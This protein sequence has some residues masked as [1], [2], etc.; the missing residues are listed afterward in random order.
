MSDRTFWKY[1]SNFWDSFKDKGLFNVVWDAYYDIANDLRRYLFQTNLNKGLGYAQASVNFDWVTVILSEGNLK[2]GTTDTYQ[3]LS[4]GTAEILTL[5]DKV[6]N[7]TNMYLNGTHFTID[8]TY[9]TWID[10]DPAPEGVILWCETIKMY[11]SH[12][13]STFGNYVGED[14]VDSNEYLNLI[15]GLMNS[16]W[17]GP[18]IRHIRNGL[19]II[20]GGEYITSEGMVISQDDTVMELNTSDGVVVY[21]KEATQKWAWNVG[22]SLGKYDL[23]INTV[24]VLDYIK[25]P[26]WWDIYGMN[27]FEMGGSG[28]VLPGDEFELNHIAKRFIWGIQIDGGLMSGLPAGTEAAISR[29]MTNINPAYTSHHTI[30]YN[31]FWGSNGDE[32]PIT[33]DWDE[34]ASTGG[35]QID[36][37]FEATQSVTFNEVSN[38][39]Y[40]D[41][42]ASNMSYDDYHSADN[43][44]YNLDN[45]SLVF[46]DELTICKES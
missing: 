15:T 38:L 29:F 26:S 37:T 27:L 34:Y 19:N 14:A 4:E 21:H 30:V 9:L 33:D 18:E 25:D 11:G 17:M 7:P 28:S 22:D 16:Y 46:I 10:S 42:A 23:S 6:D 35:I 1:L 43:P 31:S 36:R 12:L 3:V 41:F 24:E 20:L 40:G 45:E 2:E 39:M 13:Q 5:Q 8:G 32:L 44:A